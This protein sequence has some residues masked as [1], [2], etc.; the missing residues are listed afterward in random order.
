[1][2]DIDLR[3]FDLNLLKALDVLDRERSVT[4][5]AKRLNIGQP[6]MSHALARLRQVF[7]DKLFVRSGTGVK[8]TDRALELIEPLRVA[9]A[10]IDATLLAQAAPDPKASTRRHKIGMTDV[11][12][13][14]VTSRLCKALAGHAPQA[15]LAILNADRTNALTMLD[16]GELDLAIGLFPTIPG[17]LD[18]EKLFEEDFVCVYN[19]RL[20]TAGSPISIEEFAVHEHVLVILQGDDRGF[21]DVALE[22]F[23]L[24]RKIA[25]TTTFFLLAG[26]LA[27]HLPLIAT[28]P[29]HFAETSLSGANMLVSELPFPSPRMTVSMVWHRRNE[30]NATLIMLRTLLRKAFSARS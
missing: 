30:G 10:Q 20:I 24:T 18:S 11:V 7:D 4:E 22:R 15:S 13:S 17:W 26:E 27:Q 16:R 6:A 21:A 5:A 2:P 9:L 3:N 19:P 23:N 29:R 25:I 8:P 12:A 28:L 14:A 1:M